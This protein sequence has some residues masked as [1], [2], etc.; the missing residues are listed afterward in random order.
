[1]QIIEIIEEVIRAAGAVGLPILEVEAAQFDANRHQVSRHADGFPGR[2]ELERD[3]PCERALSGT[4][5]TEDQ[6]PW[7]VWRDDD[8]VDGSRWDWPRHHTAPPSAAAFD[9]RRLPCQL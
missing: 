7:D 4:R 6:L 5:R 8:L 9:R 1:M 3:P 2:A